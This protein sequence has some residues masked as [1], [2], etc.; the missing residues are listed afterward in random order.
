MDRQIQKK[1]FLRRY[2]WYIGGGALL[3]VLLLWLAF[4]ST[5]S[6]MTVDSADVTISTV[7]RGTFFQATGGNWI[8]VLD[9]SGKKAYRRNTAHPSL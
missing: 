4:G 7:T 6:T 2:A 9:K 8:Y 1:S 3:V 5:A